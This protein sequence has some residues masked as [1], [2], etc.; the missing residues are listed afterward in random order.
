MTCPPH[1]E[2]ERN[3]LVIEGGVIGAVLLAFV[4]LIAPAL[5]PATIDSLITIVVAGA[6]GAV[7]SPFIG[8]L[9]AHIGRRM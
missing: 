9:A 3:D 2:A 4:G 1:L 7:A 8:R 6:L 5:V